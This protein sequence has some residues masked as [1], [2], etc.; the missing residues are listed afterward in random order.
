MSPPMPQRARAL[1]L[2]RST[3][4]RTPAGD[5][6]YDRSSTAVAAATEQYGRHRGESR[7]GLTRY[8][9]ADYPH[10]SRAALRVL[11]DDRKADMTD[12]RTAV[13]QPTGRLNMVAAPAFKSLVEETVAAG[14]T[15]IVVDLGQVTFIDSSG[16]GA[17][18]A[19]L[20]ATRQAGGD[21]RIAGVPDQVLTVLRLT[22]LDR[23]LRAHPSVADASHD[24]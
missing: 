19:G 8:S 6:P 4:P 9:G 10:T 24:W 2:H 15:R 20:K 7:P 18:I 12:D 14:Q 11:T 1:P 5:T 23:V 22:N 17:L 13:L 21:L 3:D 16:L